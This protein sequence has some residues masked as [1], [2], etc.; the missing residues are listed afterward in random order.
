VVDLPNEA[1]VTM[2]CG[3]VDDVEVVEARCNGNLRL[4]SSFIPSVILSCTSVSAVVIIT[5]TVLDSGCMTRYARRHKSTTCVH[6]SNQM[7][8]LTEPSI[9]VINTI[10]IVMFIYIVITID[11]L[12]TTY[13]KVL[14][15][16][17][18][19]VE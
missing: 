4:S 14:K 8:T 9:Q 6:T 13:H 17:R 10:V 7:A 11:Q 12:L 3:L 15:A 16:M 18:A 1:G 19:V 5:G 2:T